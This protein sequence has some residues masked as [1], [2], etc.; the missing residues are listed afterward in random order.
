[1]AVRQ[2]GVGGLVAG[3]G[4]LVA[5]QATA[6]AD[7]QKEVPQQVQV[8]G[9]SGAH[10]RSDS[11]GARVVVL[12]DELLRHGDTRLADALQRVPGVTV[13]QGGPRGSDIRMSGL[14]GGYTQLLLNGEP[15]PPGFALD[16]LSP[17]SVERV[18]ISRSA[19]VD[20]SSQAV[21]GSINIVLRR[22]ASR[23]QREIKLGTGV[24]LG[25]A[26]AS[27]DAQVGDRDGPLNWG[28]GVGLAAERQRWP[29]A[30]D[31]RVLDSTSGAVTQAYTTSKHEQDRTER[32]TLSPRASWTLSPQHSLSTDHFWRLFQS[33]G[34]ALDR[35]TSSAG[36]WPP[37]A[38]N[39]L[40]IHSRGHSLR[41]RAQWTRVQDD[42]ARW[43]LKF[44]LTQQRRLSEADFDGWDFD[45][46]WV[47]DAHV[48][49]LALDR[50]WSQAGRWRL[51]GAGAHTWAAGW[52]AEE[53]RRSEDRLQRE[54]PLPGG[55]PVENLDE[56]YTA[57]V[58][59][60]AAF[61]QDEWTM[62]AGWTSTLGLRWEGLLLNSRGNVFEG[63]RRRSSVFSP[64]LQA[65]WRVPGSKDEWRLGLARS[66]KAPT[67]RELMPRRY[68]A[69]NNS[70]TTPDL[71]GNA[72]LLPELAW[73]LDVGWQ[74]P[75]GAGG[76]LSM[77]AY[78]KRVEQVIVDEL[79]QQGGS[80]VLRR[81]NLGTAW[82]RGAE[83]EGRVAM[84]SLWPT[85]P[86]LDLRGTLAV[87]QSRVAAVPGPHNRLA[88]Q[89][90][91]SL[92]LGLDHRPPAARLSWGASYGL[93]RGAP[94]RLSATRFADK[95]DSHQLD[96]YAVW[97]LDARTQWRLALNNLLQR[98]QVDQRRV[99]AGSTEHMLTDTW[100]TGAALRL[101][102]EMTL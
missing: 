76:L 44:G 51:A 83:L 91:L 77:T 50:G 93:Q 10:A 64:V 79:L 69:N 82:V 8:Q 74:R 97:K 101:T 61:V 66:Y 99:R 80:W 78:A 57:R 26:T 95:A 18:E 56:V 46:T 17:D 43:E 54:Q 22:V 48:H 98:D 65:V 87:N 86:A 39:D 12:R 73:G 49:S 13:V 25:R 5:A 53:T 88:Q 21:A 28:L 41:S 58:Q 62:G 3:W 37:L 6:P 23:A 33:S 31:Q 40:F 96:A 20:Q 90:P 9:R 30:L 11:V 32:L 68:V 52:D 45:G 38:R 7:V 16:T 4:A 75:L 102:L 2:W 60:L 24:L 85:A 36:A 42:G 15:V 27:A 81:T 55:L 70:P 71:Q 34:A 59:R 35:R 100:Q 47:R 72:A 89:T 92:N 19:S 29:M 14:G 84:R 63:V 94:Q 1:M 67:P